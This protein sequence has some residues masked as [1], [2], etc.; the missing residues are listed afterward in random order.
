M[1]FAQIAVIAVLAVG[2][3]VSMPAVR[4]HEGAPA[5]IPVGTPPPEI[6]RTTVFT[7]RGDQLDV[8]HWHIVRGHGNLTSTPPEE[9][10]YSPEAVYIDRNAL[11]L[12]GNW[13]DYMDVETGRDH[14]YISGRVESKDVYLYGRFAV[15][16]KIPIGNGFWPA[17]W[18]R[19]PHEFG[20][21]A[22]QI[23]IMDGF[24]SQTNGFSASV[25][26]WSNGVPV[27]NACVIV[28]N[29]QTPTTCKQIGNPQRKLVNYANDWHTFGIDWRPD[30]ITWF[31][32]NKPYWTV[33]Q[34]VPNLPMIIVLDLTLGGPQ[35]GPI[36][37]HT[38]FPATFSIASVAISR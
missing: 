28:Q 26:K 33:T 30:H 22:A 13:G 25:A 20:P 23:D 7:F 16:L 27:S 9:Q 21:L 24:G 2:A 19:T 11:R 31:V 37:K 8:R 32:D 38:R 29:Y 34:G 1:R 15:Q 5:E 12:S 10:Y 35:D 6:A 36:T 4:A 18:L 3:I 17:V 14:T